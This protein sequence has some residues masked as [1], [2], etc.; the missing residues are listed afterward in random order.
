MAHTAAFKRASTTTSQIYELAAQIMQNLDGVDLFTAINSTPSL[1]RLRDDQLCWRKKLDWS[2]PTNL[3]GKELRHIYQ[4]RLRAIEN[5]QKGDNPL[6]I[7]L[8]RQGYSE[9][10]ITMGPN[11]EIYIFHC[12]GNT[13]NIIGA[14]EVTQT[15]Q[16]AF[17]PESI[18]AEG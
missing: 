3:G 10:Q 9:D 18:F 2:G 15:G 12:E 14:T 8:T 7:D 6:R 17:W 11:N 1:Q 16:P 13:T 4:H 5:I